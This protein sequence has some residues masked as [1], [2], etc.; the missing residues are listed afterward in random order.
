MKALLSVVIA[1]HVSLVAD[2][3]IV[4]KSGFLIT[5][6][7]VDKKEFYNCHLENFFCG[8]DECFK[9]NRPAINQNIDL[10]LYSQDENSTYKL[11]MS[12]PIRYK[13]DKYLGDSNVSIIGEL[14]DK[15]ITVRDILILRLSSL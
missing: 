4:K 1:L 2:A 6:S 5:Q 14:N 9:R 8:E 3:L 15:I 10:V 13:L 12:K 7:C 11:E